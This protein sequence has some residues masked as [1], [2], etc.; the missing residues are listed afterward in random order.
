MEPSTTE[1]ESDPL[2][3]SGE[4]VL[5]LDFDP[6][7]GQGPVLGTLENDGSAPVDATV[8]TS[9][10]GQVLATPSV[11]GQGAATLPAYAG[12]AADFAVVRVLPVGTEDHLA[13]GARDFLIGA[14]VRLDEI[15]SGAPADNGDNLL[16]RGLFDGSG[17]YKLQVDHGRL[18][19]RLA[20]TEGELV[21]KLGQRL[22]PRRWY[23][24]ECRRVGD[25][26]QLRAAELTANG[27]GAW[28]TASASGPI[29]VIDVASDVPLSVGGK[30]NADGAIVITASDQLNGQIDQVLVLMGP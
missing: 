22:D 12:G 13:P 15:T 21:A 24:T 6:P 11:D 16:Q 26:V 2:L 20:G 8:V 17:Q 19:C 14:D 1:S 3:A 25:S 4:R 9:G 29:G 5:V 27:T 7:E 18:S 10:R 30:L 23:R 28:S